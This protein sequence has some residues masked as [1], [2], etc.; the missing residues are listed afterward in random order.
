MEYEVYKPT[1]TEEAN[2]AYDRILSECMAE[3]ANARARAKERMRRDDVPAGYQ[4]ELPLG[5]PSEQNSRS[6]Q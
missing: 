5:D 3:L 2:R 6:E 4:Y 1:S